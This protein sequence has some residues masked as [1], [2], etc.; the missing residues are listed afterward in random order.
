MLDH[1]SGIIH[2]EFVPTFFSVYEDDQK[3]TVGL[4]FPIASPFF[5]GTKSER[6]LQAGNRFGGYF[7][8]LAN[9]I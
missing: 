3:I 5:S 4:P 7:F 8:S 9:L 1:L 2:T 6:F